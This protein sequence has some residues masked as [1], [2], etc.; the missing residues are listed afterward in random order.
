MKI[1]VNS[2]YGTTQSSGK[3]HNKAVNKLFTRMYKNYWLINNIYFLNKFI[4]F[5]K[6]IFME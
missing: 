6:S 3:M 1:K 5:F 4:S 2:S